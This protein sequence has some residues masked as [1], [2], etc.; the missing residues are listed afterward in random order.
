M[1]PMPPGG[2]TRE[3]VRDYWRQRI[4]TSPQDAPLSHAEL[5]QFL[6][7]RNTFLSWLVGI[8]SEAVQNEPPGPDTCFEL[9]IKVLPSLAAVL[10]FFLAWLVFANFPSVLGIYPM[11]IL[12]DD[13][14]CLRNRRHI[15]PW[16][17]YRCDS[18]IAAT[19]IALVV[20]LLVSGLVLV[21]FFRQGGMVL[22]MDG[23]RT[24]KV[25]QF[26]HNGYVLFLLIFLLVLI[27]VTLFILKNHLLV[28]KVFV[29]ASNNIL[30]LGLPSFFAVVLFN[31]WH[32][33]KAGYVTI[34]FHITG[35]FPSWLEDLSS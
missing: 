4:A 6:K 16:H 15:L 24:K 22:L 27:V 34:F 29:P 9:R 26:V 30:L 17:T 21:I 18:L 10:V 5:S 23:Q 2:W 12:P 19:D 25:I 8:R 13:L 20:S 33:I 28:Q 1:P 7:T 14:L 11:M 32:S 3:S 35:R 31:L